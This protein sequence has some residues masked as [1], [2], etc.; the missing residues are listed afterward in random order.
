MALSL[1]IAGACFALSIPFGDFNTKCIMMG[2]DYQRM[3]LDPL[4]GVGP[5]PERFLAPLVAWLLGLSGER[6]WLFSHGTLIVFLALAHHLT[7]TRSKDRIWATVFTYGLALSA[8]VATYR[9][10]VGYS[11]P[12]TFVLLCLCILW[13]ERTHVFWLLLGLG[14]LNH[15]QTLFLWPWLVYER[16]RTAKIGWR[17]GA[18]AA[19]AVA[20]YV[21]A[22]SWLLPDGPTTGN[23]TDFYPAT[24]SFWWYLEAVNWWLG[25]DLWLLI[26]PCVVFCFG[27]FVVALLW[28]LVGDQRREAMIGCGLMLVAICAILI[29]AIDIYRFVALL[30]FPMI[31]AMHRR[32][33]PTRR[34]LWVLI[35]SIGLTIAIR[36]PHLELVSYLMQ[37]RVDAQLA[38][39]VC[40]TLTGVLPKCWPWFVGYAVFVGLLA[41]AARWSLPRG[42]RA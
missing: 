1:L 14:L 20:V 6:Y 21:L 25:L 42:Q 19:I 34:S 17:D 32:Y 8:T 37:T 40:P 12:L 3:S 28:D 22:R 10:L 35:G 38:G 16:S 33:L 36:K 24:L 2:A 26:L 27:G 30:A 41:W 39:H 31:A 23:G 15:G 7:W 29:I 5:H 11:D 9:G 18:L 4:G 13:L